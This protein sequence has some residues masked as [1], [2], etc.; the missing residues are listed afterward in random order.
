[1]PHGKTIWELT[2]ESTDEDEDLNYKTGV[3]AR[4]AQVTNLTVNKNTC[5][6]QA[7]FTYM[8]NPYGINLEPGGRWH[9][10]SRSPTHIISTA[11]R[12][13]AQDIMKDRFA[14]NPRLV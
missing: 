11:I 8:K 1:M 14:I 12:A 6:L 7:D 10:P 9:K 3:F 13:I 5:V 2:G 4:S